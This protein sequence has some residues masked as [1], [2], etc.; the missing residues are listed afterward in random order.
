MDRKNVLAELY[1][2]QVKEDFFYSKVKKYESPLQMSLYGDDISV[3]VYKNLIKTVHDN[4][5]LLTQDLVKYSRNL[6]LLSESEISLDDNGGSGGSGKVHKKPKDNTK[7]V[8]LLTNHKLLD[9]EEAVKFIKEYKV[10][11]NLI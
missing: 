10:L 4:L 11:N 2:G 6:R 9:D 7:L 1:K 8:N 5:E 3:D